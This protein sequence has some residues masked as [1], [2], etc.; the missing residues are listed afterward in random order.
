[1]WLSTWLPLLTVG[2]VAGGHL[3]IVI[4]HGMG[5]NCCHSWS[6]GY[7]KQLLEDNM[8][9]V[10]VRSLMIGSSPGQDTTN[11]FFKPVQDQVAEVCDKIRGDDR[12]SNGYNAI[13]FSQ[14]G[15]F[16]RAVAQKCPQGMR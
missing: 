14:G 5:D 11:G 6:M 7:I 16:L 8:P 2:S 1:M 4:W 9:G 12:L 10:Y 15:Q 13:G 3:P